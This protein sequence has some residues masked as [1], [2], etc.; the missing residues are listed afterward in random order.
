[1]RSPIKAVHILGG[2]KAVAIDPGQSRSEPG[3]G[4]AVLLNP[5]QIVFV[6]RHKVLQRT[7]TDHP[8]D[9]LIRTG[10]G[11]QCQQDQS[12]PG[13]VEEDLTVHHDVNRPPIRVVLIVVAVIVRASLIS[14]P[15]CGQHLDSELLWDIVVG[16]GKLVS[17]EVRASMS[18][19][20][21][22]VPTRF[23]AD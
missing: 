15:R 7:G 5:Q 13:I 18:H 21:N 10:F 16:K 8:K 14:H 22:V 20:A 2:H 19:R 17:P 11:Y 3:I 6:I 12:V 9:I 1:L 23:H 4:L